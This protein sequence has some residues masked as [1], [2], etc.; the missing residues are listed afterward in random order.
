MRPPAE[1]FEDRRAVFIDKDGTLVE[2]V[3]YNVDPRKLVFTPG[4]IEALSRLADAAFA[5]IIIS[6]QSGIGRGLFDR[7][8]FDRYAHVLCGRLED[9]GVFIAGIYICPHASSE[10]REVAMA[11]T[12]RK[13]A[14]GLLHQAARIHR[15]ALTQ[16]WMIGDILDD[17]E[18]GA[19]AG[20]RTVL[21]DVGNETEWRH[22]PLRLPTLRADN[23]LSAA[24]AIAA[25]DARRGQGIEAAA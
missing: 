10:G 21:L 6:N 7:P 1:G 4:A 25:C 14:P 9:A 24:R 2:D 23:L 11:C 19:R 12:C 8:A 22:A 18:A 20:C 16:S 15:I 5:L 3:A 13:P 17:V